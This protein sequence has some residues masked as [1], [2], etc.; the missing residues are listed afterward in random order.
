M[1]KPQ[2]NR[3]EIYNFWDLSEEQQQEITEGDPEEMERAEENNYVIF[4]GNH[5]DTPQILPLDMFLR[6]SFTGRSRMWDGI[7]STSYFSA[8][9]IKLSNCGSMAVIAQRFT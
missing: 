3:S 9:F 4:T 5:P 8:Y 6:T 1:T 7:Y 2:Y